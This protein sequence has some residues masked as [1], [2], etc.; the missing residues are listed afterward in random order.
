MNFI[1]ASRYV[2][3]LT[4]VFTG[5]ILVNAQPET[6]K[7]NDPAV[8]VINK[9]VQFLGGDRYLQVETQIGRGKFSVLRGP[10]VS[11]FQSFIDVI[12]FPDRERTEFKSMG[13]KTIQVNTGDSGWVF[14]GDQSVIKEQDQKQISDFHR[15]LRTSLDNVLR[16]YWKGQADLSYVG[17]RPAML[18]KRNDVVKL[19]YEDGFVVEFE[20]S[21]DDG[22]PQKALYKRPDGGSDTIKEEDRY[23]QFIEEGGIK[24]AYVIDRFTDGS[25]ASRI[26]YES[27]QFNRSIPDSIFAKPA[28]P[29]E[30]KK[31]LKF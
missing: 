4:I 3:F 29:K 18:G 20:F 21:A 13:S 6:A 11:S 10:G 28:T 23:A 1:D 24:T 16:G 15:A 5:T 12:V 30:A 17:K 31:E 22:T 14:D 2:C 9:A 27:V 25:H 26:N 8:A 19:T 7:T